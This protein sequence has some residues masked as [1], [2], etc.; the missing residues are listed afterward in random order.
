MK[1]EKE[2]R[3][4]QHCGRK[5]H[6]NS[7][8]WDLHTCSVCYRTLRQYKCLKAADQ[9]KRY[10]KWYN[11]PENREK[12]IERARANYQKKRMSEGKK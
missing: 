10:K 12:E 3:Y 2:I 11:N 5:M 7:H 6:K 9:S 1:E 8:I 4:C